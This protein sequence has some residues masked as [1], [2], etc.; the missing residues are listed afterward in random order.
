MH[1]C[2]KCGETSETQFDSCWKCGTE[3]SSPTPSGGAEAP[4]PV[5]VQAPRARPVARYRRFRGTFSSW[6]S[7]L[8]QA[9]E[10]ATSIGPERLITISH[11]EDNDDG[12]VVVWY[13]SGAEEDE[14]G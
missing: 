6:D 4:A 13:W 14:A 8:S 7:L 2:P 11:S 3:F 9:A 5:G 12:V 1:R 10:F